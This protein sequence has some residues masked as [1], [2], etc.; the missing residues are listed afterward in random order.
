MSIRRRDD[1]L[2]PFRVLRCKIDDPVDFQADDDNASG[3]N[4]RKTLPPLSEVRLE[5]FDVRLI[6]AALRDDDE[7]SASA[8]VRVLAIF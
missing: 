7:G 6:H 5:E 1:Y 8:L 2:R 4:P 3:K